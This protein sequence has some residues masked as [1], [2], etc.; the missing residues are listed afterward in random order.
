MSQVFAMKNAALLMQRNEGLLL[1]AW[2]EYHASLLGHTNLFVFD[3]GSTDEST[4]QILTELETKG[5]H[6]ITQYSTP[7][8][9]ERKGD[10][11]M[12]K[13]SQLQQEGY[14]FMH[15]L[16]CDEFLGVIDD[17]NTVIFTR[18]ALEGC[19]QLLLH[20]D[21]YFGVNGTFFNASGGVGQFQFSS[22]DKKV[23]FGRSRIRLLDLGF[24]HGGVHGSDAPPIKTNIIHMHLHNRAYHMRK[25]MAAQK[26]RF[27]VKNFSPDNMK[28]YRDGAGAHLRTAF[29]QDE[30]GMLNTGTIDLPNFKEYM[31]IHNIPFPFHQYENSR[32]DLEDVALRFSVET[33]Q[34]NRPEIADAPLSL[35]LKAVE[36]CQICVASKGRLTDYLSIN[37]SQIMSEKFYLIDSKFTGEDLEHV[38]IV[39]SSLLSREDIY[40]NDL[41]CLIELLKPGFLRFTFL[42]HSVLDQ[43]LRSASKEKGSLMIVENSLDFM[44]AVVAALGNPA[45]SLQLAVPNFWSQPKYHF[46][47]TFYSIVDT[48]DDAVIM[49]LDRLESASFVSS[50]ID[51]KYLTPFVVNTLRDIAMS[52]KLNNKPINLNHRVD[53][54]RLAH[55]GRPKGMVIK[56]K[57]SQWMRLLGGE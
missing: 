22:K 13:I 29:F 3:N 17:T 21:G 9:F 43:A 24:H 53:L 36:D 46:L 38:V 20:Q 6:V 8:D 42:L 31:M 7:N 26:L 15:P 45:S 10:I 49:K 18:E 51:L 32:I 2:A 44:S 41:N 11:I 23:F 48:A 14:S 56:R 19:L 35:M 16:D 25:I 57:L 47:S 1:K 34:K 12:D 55:F 54:M 52:G 33:S 5:I 37:L 28:A 30:S 4:L 40:I 50:S 27:R 39:A